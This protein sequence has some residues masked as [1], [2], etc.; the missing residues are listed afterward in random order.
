LFFTGRLPEELLP[1]E[2]IF[3]DLWRLHPKEYQDVKMRGR[4]VKTPRWQQAYGQDYYYSG[5]TNEAKPV[6]EI[7]RPLLDWAK[8]TIDDRLNGV[9][10]NWY[11]GSLGHYIGKH[12]DSI[13]N[14]IP[15]SPIV[16]VSFGDERPFRLRPWKGTGFTDFAAS[17]GSVF[18][19]PWQTN[20]H[21]QH[22]VPASKSWK[23]KRISVTFRAFHA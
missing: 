22:E 2:R 5:Q 16:T 11:D 6:P 13:Q 21:F 12:R 8:N 9:L 4:L 14:L 1:D 19:L 7:V 10:L 15:G 17:N 23:G 3:A 18:I 20:L